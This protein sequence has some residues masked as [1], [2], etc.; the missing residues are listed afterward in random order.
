MTIA[1]AFQL[2]LSYETGCDDVVIGTDVANRNDSETAGL[3]GFFVNQLVLRTSIAGSTSFSALLRRMRTACVDAY[4]HQD[5]PFERVVQAVNPP[6]D[7]SRM[8]LFQIKLVLQDTPP[9]VLDLP[10]LR[11]TPLTVETDTAKY[12]LLLTIEN[13]PALEGTIEYATDLYDAPR[14]ARLA[15]RWRTLLEQ[16][17]LAPDRSPSELR[18]AVDAASSSLA[19]EQERL[20]RE[21][22]LRKLRNVRRTMITGVEP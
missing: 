4:A 22:G 14:I 2:L 13:T 1:A 21:E 7:A 12:D 15:D 19:G 5:V 8:P 16:C 9:A 6:R 20:R 3:I 10:S 17:A 11:V 18:A